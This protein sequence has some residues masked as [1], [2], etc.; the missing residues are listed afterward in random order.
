MYLSET[1]QIRMPP[2]VRG[3]RN[4]ARIGLPLRL[5]KA[6]QHSKLKRLP[7]AERA[8]V[9][10]STVADIESGLRVPT[11]GTIARLASALGVSAGWL[12]FGL[13]EM[14]SALE[15]VTTDGMGM[16][17]RASRLQRGLTKAALARMVKLS[18]SAYAKIEDG[19]QT[20]VDVLE[21]IAGALSISAPWLSFGIGP[22]Q[23]PDGRRRSRRIA[24]Q[25]TQA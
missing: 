6:R 14:G 1:V 7:L 3:K 18:P 4:P 11:V 5:A 9:A 23:R 13:G 12:G 21:S 25:D 8:G 19:G 15:S 16:R 2:M 22:E 17:L 10:A 24:Q 20:G